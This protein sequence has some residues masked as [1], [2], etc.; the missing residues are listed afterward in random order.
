MK[1]VYINEQGGLETLIY[2]DRPDPVPGPGEVLVRVRASALNHLDIFARTGQNQVSTRG[3]P[4]I[5]GCDMAGEVAGLGPGVTQFSEGQR[6]LVDYDVKCGTCHYCSIGR[7]ELCRRR[8]RLGVDADGGYAQ[9][10]KVPATNVYPIPDWMSYEEAAAIPLVFHTA[11]HCLIT[12]ANLQPGEDVL[13]NAAGSGVGSAAIQVATQTGARVIVTAGSDEKLEKARELGA[14]EGINY[15][16]EPNF[17]RRV[18]ELTG[19]LGVD[20]VFD[21]VGAS[22]WDENFECIKPGGRLVICG[23]TGGH[24]ASIRLGQLFQR[25]I[26]ILGSGGRSRREFADMM[27]LVH[28]GRFRGVVG[29]VFPLEQAREAHRTMEERNF[30]GKLVLQVP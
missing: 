28:R 4:R 1:A 26:S 11:W 6:V 19:G 22:I 29:R 12:R 30:F 10:C 14:A 17:S 24:R 2:G 13:I 7:D 23:V 27:K 15:N 16:K 20:L 18:K 8:T 9:Y 5:L 21:S 3:F 25:G